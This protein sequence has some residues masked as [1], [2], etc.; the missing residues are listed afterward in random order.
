MYKRIL[1]LTGDQPWGDTAM[2]Y[3]IALAAATGAE[4]SLLS[5][6]PPPIVTGMPDVTMSSA[7]VLEGIVAQSKTVLAGIVAAAEQA[8]V[9]CTVHIRW[10]NTVDILLHTATEDDCDLIIV[11]SHTYTWR[12]R[13]LLRYLLK[14]VPARASQPLLVV[15]APPEECSAG[16][17]WSRLLVVHDGSPSSAAAVQ[18]TLALAQEAAFDICLLHL[19]AVRRRHT[20]DAWRLA[21]STQDMFA[22]ATAQATMAGVSHDT[23][24]ASGNFVTAIVETAVTKDCGAIV[25]GVAPSGGWRR[26]VSQHT[27]Q[28]VLANTTI[29]ILLMHRSATY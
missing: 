23:L 11:G 5:V 19:N 1:A 21:S 7:V 4:L 6:P 18:Y 29:P 26:R 10:G 20:L 13:W 12:G 15:T 14:K 9:P 28:A 2:E 22:L 8:G 17:A 24:S 16:A 25:L 3:A 27:V